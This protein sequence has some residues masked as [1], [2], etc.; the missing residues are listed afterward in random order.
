MESGE[1][2]SRPIWNCRPGIKRLGAAARHVATF[3]GVPLSTPTTMFNRSMA[4]IVCCITSRSV[5]GDQTGLLHGGFFT[6]A[7]NTAPKGWAGSHAGNGSIGVQMPS[8]G[9]PWSSAAMA[10]RCMSMMGSRAR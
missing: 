3:F 1:M 10:C 6:M 5:I 7:M 2:E 8:G 4:A 9:G